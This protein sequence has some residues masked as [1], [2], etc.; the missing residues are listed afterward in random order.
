MNEVIFQSN[1][2][3]RIWDYLVSH[4]HLLL[5]SRI[6]E[7]NID[8]IEIV[9]EGVSFIQLPTLL[10]GIVIKKSTENKFKIETDGKEYFID[11]INFSVFKNTTEKI[12]TEKLL[13]ISLSKLGEKIN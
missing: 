6:N 7:E 4:D 10:K 3:F 11:A 2:T 5:H 13:S 12:P 8:N 9:F 1:R